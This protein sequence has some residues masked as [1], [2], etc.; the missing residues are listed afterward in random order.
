MMLKFFLL[1]LSLFS[2]IVLALPLNISENKIRDYIIN[3]HPQQLALLKRLVDINSGTSNM[4]GVYQV[5]NIIRQQLQQLGFKTYWVSEPNYM[6]RAGTLVAERKGNNTQRLLLIGHLDTVF[7]P[8]SQFQKFE[9]KTHTAKGPGII[10]DK[11]GVVVLLY[12]L[13]ALASI[14]AL[15]NAT[16]TVVLTGDEEDSG[17]PATISRKALIE[18][19]KQSDVALDFEPS[20][21][22][23]TASIARRGISNWQIETRGNESHSATIFLSNVGDGAIFELAR[24]LNSMR[25]QL[26]GEKNLVFNPGI[27]LGGSLMHYDKKLAKGEVFGKENVVAKTALARGDFRFLNE[28]Q[29]N[30]FENKVRNIVNANL[31]GTQATVTFENGIP[32]MP[33]TENNLKLLEQYSAVSVDLNYGSVKPLDAGVRGAGDISYIAHLV[34]ANLAGL[35]PT[36]IGTHSVIES[37]DLSSLPIQIERAALLIYRLSR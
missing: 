30:A 33:P 7:P 3:T 6:K 29:K 36:G 23:N 18:A 21:T 2:H 9:L 10:D 13:K 1:I 27:I 24:I 22:L 32:A 11:G 8:E 25:T 5:G 15:E 16:I 20:I 4:S 26:Q 12:A 34:P 17:K 35:G 37:L 28:S 31:V 14:N 19:A